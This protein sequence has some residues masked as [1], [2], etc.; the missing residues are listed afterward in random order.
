M[1]HISLDT[2]L[3]THVG[4]QIAFP[5]FDG[6][7]ILEIGVAFKNAGCLEEGNLFYDCEYVEWRPGT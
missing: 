2:Y 7:E 4:L 5:T 3:V 1:R 6:S